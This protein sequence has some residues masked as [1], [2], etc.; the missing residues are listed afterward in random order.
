MYNVKRKWAWSNERT[1]SNPS[2]SI[3]ADFWTWTA[4][5]GTNPE[6]NAGPISSSSGDISFAVRS[7]PLS[8]FQIIEIKKIGTLEQK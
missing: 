5:S 4:L 7:V 3:S 1:S 2:S 6:G 8:F